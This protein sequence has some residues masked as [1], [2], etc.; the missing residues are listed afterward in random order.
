MIETATL[1]HVRISAQKLRLVANQ[2]RGLSVEKAITLLTFHNKKGAVL[3][4]KALSSAIANAEHNQSA[5][6]DDLVVSTIFVDKGTSMRRF[7]ARA[8]GRANRINKP[9]CHLTVAVTDE[10]ETRN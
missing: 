5:D 3:V 2:V 9:T 6:I 4:K 10:S 8:K 7:S 1:K